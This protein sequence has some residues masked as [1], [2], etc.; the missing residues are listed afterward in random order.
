MNGCKRQS[1]SPK[2]VTLLELFF[3][4]LHLKCVLQSQGEGE[5]ERMTTVE[6]Y[7]HPKSFRTGM[8]WTE[9]RHKMKWNRI[10]FDI[11]SFICS[12]SFSL[13]WCQH[14]E[15]SAV[16]FDTRLIKRSSLFF[17]VFFLCFCFSSEIGFEIHG[18]KETRASL[19]FRND[20]VQ[21]IGKNDE[22]KTN[23]SLNTWA[24]LFTFQHEFQL[25][26]SFQSYFF[27][28]CY[29]IL[30]IFF[31][32]FPV[33]KQEKERERES[34]IL[35]LGNFKHHL[36]IQTIRV[37]YFRIQ[38]TEE[39]NKCAEVTWIAI[40]CNCCM[41]WITF[42]CWKIEL[43]YYLIRKCEWEHGVL[44]TH[45]CSNSEKG[46]WKLRTPWAA[47]VELTTI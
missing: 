26:G 23:S 39:T 14:C 45:V 47:Q 29:Q 24:L 38:C 27:G 22:K 32:H 35:V 18:C 21:P 46:A 34:S 37:I 16:S 41:G 15:L 9:K 19:E 33:A 44:M 4:R 5:R 30:R 43:W 31:Q 6:F 13:F 28:E 12:P 7:A 11:F 36:N 1:R 2:T 17:T 25:L 3:T 8:C 10:N 20:C 40:E 42:S